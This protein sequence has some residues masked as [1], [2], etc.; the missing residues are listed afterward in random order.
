[1]PASWW[2]S[3]R[4]TGGEHR[5]RRGSGWRRAVLDYGVSVLE[6]F[7]RE[8][9]PGAGR[10]RVLPERGR[11]TRAVAASP[12]VPSSALGAGAASGVASRSEEHTS[13]LQSLAY[14]V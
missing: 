13:E 4:R 5:D 10:D 11:P 7:P 9:V 3:R 12:S 6:P 1:M 14:L 8:R 2:G